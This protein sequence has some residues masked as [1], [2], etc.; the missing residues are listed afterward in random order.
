[1]VPAVWKNAVDNLG[2]NLKLVMGVGQAQQAVVARGAGLVTESVRACSCYS[3]SSYRY[4]SF[5]IWLFGRQNSVYHRWIC[6]NRS[7]ICHNRSRIWQ[8]E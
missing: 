1:M 3:V 4:R 8:N 2:G 5:R 6:R 7:R